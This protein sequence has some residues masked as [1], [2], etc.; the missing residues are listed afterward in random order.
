MTVL[1]FALGVPLPLPTAPVSQN[2]FFC[3]RPR[4]LTRAG[5]QQLWRDDP[6]IDD[7]GNT[8]WKS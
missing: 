1:I 4:R 8:G 5:Q 7:T 2:Q 3:L 6:G